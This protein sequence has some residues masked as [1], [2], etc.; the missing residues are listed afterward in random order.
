MSWANKF[1]PTS[2]VIRIVE[3]RVGPSASS[4]PVG[5]NSFARFS[6]LRPAGCDALGEQVRPYNSGHSHC[7]IPCV[8]IGIVGTCRGEFIRPLLRVTPYRAAMP[9]AN[10]FAPTGIDPDLLGALSAAPLE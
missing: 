2:R 7:W 3:Y 6:A 10:K 5:A 1:A 8:A 4:V 9:L